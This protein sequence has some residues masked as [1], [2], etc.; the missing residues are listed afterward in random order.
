M[1]I[2]RYSAPEFD[3]YGDARQTETDDGWR[4]PSQNLE[5]P[6]RL[7]DFLLAVSRSANEA[8]LVELALGFGDMGAHISL[9]DKVK[10]GVD[11]ATT[12]APDRFIP[13]FEALLGLSLAVDAVDEVLGGSKG[14]GL[15][16]I[17]R[18]DGV[19]RFGAKVVQRH[20][21]RAAATT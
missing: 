19:E 17:T 5:L 1:Q 10:N 16:T 8:L 4:A 14:A 12:D 7:V 18:A 6:P 2:S 21:G 9:P 13:Q 3:P 15:A 20:A 11:I